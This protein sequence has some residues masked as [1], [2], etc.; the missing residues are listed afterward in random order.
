MHGGYALALRRNRGYLN[1]AALVDLCEAPVT[2]YLVSRWEL[3]LAANLIIDSKAAYLDGRQAFI[4]HHAKGQVGPFRA[5]WQFHCVECDGSNVTATKDLKA[6]W[7][8]MHT[9]LVY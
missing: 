5:S 7:L 6:S 4:D 3:L 1:Q 8:Y 9:H 2:R